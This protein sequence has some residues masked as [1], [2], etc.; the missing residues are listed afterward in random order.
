VIISLLTETE[1]LNWL[2]VDGRAILS[3]IIE[4]QLGEVHQAIDEAGG[5]VVD[6]LTVRDWVCLVVEKNKKRHDLK[7]DHNA[8]FT[9]I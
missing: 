5:C 1:L 8:Q 7:W 6:E 4:E 9:V 2:N 3:G